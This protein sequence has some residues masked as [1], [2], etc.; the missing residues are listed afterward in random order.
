MIYS[1]SH[2]AQWEDPLRT[3]G[4]YFLAL[5]VLSAA[6]YFPWTR[7]ALK[8]ASITLGGMHA[9]LLCKRSPF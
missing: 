3:L 5:G 2:P 8:Y 6:H 4:S 9:S 1:F 7:T